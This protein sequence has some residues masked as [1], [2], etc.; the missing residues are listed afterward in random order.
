[1]IPP[2]KLQLK[3]SIENALHANCFCTNILSFCMPSLEWCAN[4]NLRK[5]W[6]YWHW[7]FQTPTNCHF[8]TRTNRVRKHFLWQLTIISFHCK[9][10][11]FVKSFYPCTL[12]TF[13]ICKNKRVLIK[14]YDWLPKLK[15]L[16]FIISNKVNYNCIDRSLQSVDKCWEFFSVK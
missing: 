13:N 16:L 4:A 3:R 9:F 2:R 12:S 1:M 11:I 6:L 14:K 7:S 15:L 5:Y 10:H 8:Y